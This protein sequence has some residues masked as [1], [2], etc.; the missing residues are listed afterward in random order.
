MLLVVVLCRLI[1]CE[2]RFSGIDIVLLFHYIASYHSI[3]KELRAYL[4]R[5]VPNILN[6]PIITNTPRKKRD[7]GLHQVK[8]ANLY[9]Y[10]VRK[11]AEHW[12]LLVIFSARHRGLLARIVCFEGVTPDFQS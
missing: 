6:K 5:G 1:N 12:G 7:I 9:R 11:D 8:Y 4:F 3:S 2:N 10:P